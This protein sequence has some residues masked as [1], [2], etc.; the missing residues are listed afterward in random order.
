MELMSGEE[1][2]RENK[3]KKLVIGALIVTIVLIIL[4]VVAILILQQ[5]ENNK[6]KLM[7]NGKSKTF[8]EDFMITDEKTGTNY[9]SIAQVARLVG[10]NFYNGEYKQY[11]EDKTKCYVECE[12]ELAMFELNSNILYKNNAADKLNFDSYSLD[13]AVAS[14]ENSLYATPQAIQTAFNTRVIYN[15][16]N[17]TIYLETLPY[18]VEY[19]KTQVTKR[20]YTG[21]SE[22]FITQKALI[23]NML[24]VENNG[25]YGVISTKDFSSIIG[26]KYDS[27]IY[28]ENTQEFL[29]T[30]EQKMGV[31]SSKGETQIGLRY[32]EVGL[33]DGKE[34]LYY[35][36]S[37]NLYGVLN[38]KGRVLVFVEYD[39]IGI[40][41]TRFPLDNI[42]NNQFLYGNCIPLKKG[43]KWG[44][45]D[46]NG[47]II[48]N[49][50]YDELGYSETVPVVQPGNNQ[51]RNN[52]IPDTTAK[53]KSINNAV[54]VPDIEGI[55]IG[56]EKKYGIANS[57]GKII[58]PCEFDKIYSITNEGKDEF[59]L[60]KNGRTTKLTRYLEDNK[61]NVE[62]PRK[63]TNTTV[64][65]NTTT[66]STT[67]NSTTNRTTNNA[68]N[69]NESIIIM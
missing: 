17:K 63:I 58:V 42:K 26:T 31:L 20:G 66:N 5:A 53:D 37:D 61:I 15:D 43:D 49:F 29:V 56:K 18:L 6:L 8:T 62:I 4:V 47:N 24:V 35:A 52:T 64:N 9:F 45:A 68:T 34:K 69:K 67:S 21:M 57:I 32:D 55:V 22:D 50:E 38:Q 19:Y 46:K 10:Y 16:K 59:Y 3:G 14:Y 7:V 2:E 39:D 25:K 13:K 44:M 40:D 54:V 11:S 41:R 48:L 23:Q 36:K 12:D 28:L 27:M 65:T 51:N 33:I 30:S 60:E 1:K